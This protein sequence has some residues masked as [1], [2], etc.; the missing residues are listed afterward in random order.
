MLAE[1]R[2]EIGEPSIDAT[3]HFLHCSAGFGRD[4]DEATRTLN[5]M[6]D[7]GSR[8]KQLEG[9]LGGGVCFVLPTNLGE[10]K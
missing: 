4:L 1:F 5:T 6:I 10:T 7:S 3:A 8:Y 9:L 2:K